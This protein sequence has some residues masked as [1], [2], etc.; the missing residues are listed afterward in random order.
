MAL[1]NWLNVKVPYHKTNYDSL[2]IHLVGVQS[3][4]RFHKNPRPHIMANKEHCPPSLATSPIFPGTSSE[5]Q[6]L[7]QPG[8]H[9]PKIFGSK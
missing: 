5:R 2:K 6:H 8:L 7:Q 4:S 3:F 9:Q 1:L